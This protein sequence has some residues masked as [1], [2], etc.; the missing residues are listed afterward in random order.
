MA[1]QRLSPL[2][3]AKDL[4]TRAWPTRPKAPRARGGWSPGRRRG[5]RLRSSETGAA[6][7]G[8]AWT[9]ARERHGLN[10]PK[11]SHGVISPLWMFAFSLAKREMGRGETDT[12]KNQRGSRGAGN[13]INWVSWPDLWGGYFAPNPGLGIDFTNLPPSDL[14]A[15]PRHRWEIPH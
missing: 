15:S 3:D 10:L 13:S 12:A 2:Y 11:M 6:R 7:V 5:T 1:K 8:G 9:V 14:L 4:V